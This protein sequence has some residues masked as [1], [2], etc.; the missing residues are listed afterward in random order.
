MADAELK[1]AFT[2]LKNKSVETATRIKAVDNQVKKV[3]DLIIYR[4]RYFWGVSQIVEEFKPRCSKLIGPAS[5]IG[6]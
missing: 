6:S 2:E 4:E 1:K 3:T 5:I